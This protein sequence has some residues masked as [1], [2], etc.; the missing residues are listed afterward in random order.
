VADKSQK[1]EAPTPKKKAEAKKKGQVSKSPELSSWLTLLVATYAL[2]ATVR[3]VKQV[4]L[5]ALGT[6]RTASATGDPKVAIAELG[7]ALQGGLMAVLP[8]LATC[9]AVGVISQLG[10]TGLVLS[11]HPLKPDIKRINPI[12]GVKNL[13]S[14]KSLWT[15]VKQLAKSTVIIWVAYPHVTAIVDE[16][17]GHGRVALLRGISLVAAELLGM[18]RAIVW[19]V[20]VIAL[21]DYAR[22]RR[23]FKR[24]M[25]MSKQEIKDEMKQNEGNPQ[26]KGRIRSLQVQVSRN[27]MMTAVADAAV[28]I[29]NP[30][31][32]AVAL[33]YD[34]SVGGAPK[35]V[36]IGVDEVA[37]RIRERAMEAGVPIVEAK[38][39]ARALWRSCELNDEIPATLYEAVAKVL[40]FVRRVKGTLLE[41]AAVL[42]LPHNYHVDRTVLDSLP[43]RQ[44]AGRGRRARAAA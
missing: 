21:L 7:T 43:A 10:Q 13:L 37:M 1:T 9:I 32:I 25:R 3:N 6:A 30:T 5:Q 31:H 27:R 40:A 11:L 39:L 29:T 26:I 16:L 38:P 22:Q 15:T 24:D 28:V 44:H 8:I 41:S 19:T 42:P 4:V 18:V 33:A 12:K 14:P 20:L 17:S 23:S 2:P 34:P 35:V 36:A